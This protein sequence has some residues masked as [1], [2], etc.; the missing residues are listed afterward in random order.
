M[1]ECMCP[2][3]CKLLF[4]TLISEIDQSSYQTDEDK[5]QDPKPPR[6]SKLPS[7]LRKQQCGATHRV[8]EKTGSRTDVFLPVSPE[9]CKRLTAKIDQNSHP[10]TCAE[11]ASP[12]SRASLLYKEGIIGVVSFTRSLLV[13]SRIFLIGYRGTGKSTVARLVAEHLGWQSIDADPLLEAEYGSSISDIFAAE[14]ETG[15]RDKEEAI[16]D[17]LCAKDEHVIATGGGV[18]LRPQNRLKLCSSGWV[19]WLNA[20]ADTIHQRLE[21]D[22]TTASRRPNLTSGGLAEIEELLTVRHPLYEECADMRIDTTSLSPAEV[23][24]TIVENYR[25]TKLS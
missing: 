13:M 22:A 21:T 23:A 5:Q 15:F 16:L 19:V 3:G 12:V 6:H 2:T 17:R 7:Q 4:R 8:G 9:R 11:E 10:P 14:G 25:R 20:D 18:V 1:L 24:N